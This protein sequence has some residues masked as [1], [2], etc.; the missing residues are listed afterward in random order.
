M[1]AAATT[2]AELAVTH[3]AAARVFYRNRLDFCCGGRRPLAE[4]CRERDLDPQAILDAIEAEN[5]MVGER[6]RW[7]SAPL[8]V[9]VAHIVE[10]YHHRLRLALPDLVTM[11]RRVEA[12][13]AVKPD[14]P[15]GLAAHLEAMHASVLDH[16]R[17]E[18]QILFPMIVAG[19]GSRTSAPVHVMELEHEH[20][21][22]DLQGVRRLTNDLTPPPDAC[23]TWRALYLGLQQLEEELMEHIHLENNVLF[24]RAL[25]A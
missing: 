12:R 8:D 21:G 23:P 24:R 14:C 19:M 20:H 3:P 9:L 18:E 4:A 15:T 7:E 22:E 17:K 10:T 13:H 11:A 6:T 2:L 5:P 1:N 16:L 25:N